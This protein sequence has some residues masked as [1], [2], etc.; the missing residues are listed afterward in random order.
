MIW[1]FIVLA[2]LLVPQFAGA[3]SRRSEFY[4][5]PVFSDSKTYNFQGGSSVRTDTGVG[6]TIGF[7]HNFNPKLSG[8]IELEWT[9]NDYRATI[10]PGVG[11][12]NAAANLNS[13]VDTGTV[14]FLGTYNFSTG[15][16]T[17][18]VTGGA[19]WSYVDTN[20]PSGL[21]QN[22]CWFYPWVGQVCTGV[23][24][25]YSTTRFSYNAGAGLRLDAGSG[26]IRLF[27]NQ[28]WM[29]FGS[30][31]Q[32]SWTQVRLDFGTKF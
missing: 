17:P 28:Q 24:P 7:G 8:A 19:G 3:Q 13:S 32:S 14:R 9:S 5:G 22:V 23:T 11:N 4:A 20:I 25:T 12:G 30:S 18:F 6:F 27:V 15:P 1:K 29:D 2:V 10:Q 21:P 16:F 26:L 31:Y